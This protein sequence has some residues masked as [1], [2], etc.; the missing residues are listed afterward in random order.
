MTL[1]YRLSKLALWALLV[2]AVLV[3]AWTQGWGP[4]H[5]SEHCI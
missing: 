5:Y 1:A 3:I 4:R 2:G